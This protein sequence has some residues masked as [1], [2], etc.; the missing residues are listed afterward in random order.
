M[1]PLTNSHTS[2]LLPK[3]LEGHQAEDGLSEHKVRQGHRVLLCLQKQDLGRAA[4]P[5]PAGLCIGQEMGLLPSKGSSELGELTQVT[6]PIWV[7]VF[8]SA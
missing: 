2:G 5:D 6:K 1:G 7:F 4:W 3:G 8:S